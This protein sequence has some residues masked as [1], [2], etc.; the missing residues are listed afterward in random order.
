MI[1]EDDRG[2]VR[3]RSDFDVFSMMF[4]IRED[5]AVCWERDIRD[6]EIGLDG[7]VMS[8]REGG[9]DSIDT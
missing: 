7:V 5:G 2:M 6:C 8:F 3:G 4:G 1:L 9:E